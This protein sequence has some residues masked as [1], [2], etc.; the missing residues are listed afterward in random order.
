M[1][2]LALRLSSRR[3]MTSVRA[4]IDMMPI[5]M[6]KYQSPLTNC[7]NAVMPP[8]GGY[9]EPATPATGVTVTAFPFVPAAPRGRQGKTTRG[10]GRAAPEAGLSDRRGPEVDCGGG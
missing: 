4:V 7:Q 8:T 6:A 10:T 1:F 3:Q 2:V 9:G 5:G